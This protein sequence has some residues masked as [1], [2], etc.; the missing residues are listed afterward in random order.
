MDSVC[1][2][3]VMWAKPTL[4]HS[5]EYLR[6]LSCGS[7]TVLRKVRNTL[8]SLH[9]Q[10]PQSERITRPELFWKL[11]NMSVSCLLWRTASAFLVFS[12]ACCW[13]PCLR[14]VLHL[15]R[16]LYSSVLHLASVSAATFCMWLIS[17]WPLSPCFCICLNVN[18]YIEC[19]LL[20][21][22]IFSCRI[23]ASRKLNLT[24]LLML[25]ALIII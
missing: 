19:H 3:S 4:V 14:V 1:E 2:G 16:H 25:C 9:I 10:R 18:P 21:I 17:S 15:C 8:F 5:P 13:L 23:M 6:Q 24:Y 12:Y 11:P 7:Q 22:L 20:S